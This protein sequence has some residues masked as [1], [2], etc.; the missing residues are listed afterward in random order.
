M[1]EDGTIIRQITCLS[2]TS[3]YLQIATTYQFK[4]LFEQQTDLVDLHKP[5]KINTYTI[6]ALNKSICVFEHRYL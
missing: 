2:F 1:F 6:L 3:M 5:T 4:N